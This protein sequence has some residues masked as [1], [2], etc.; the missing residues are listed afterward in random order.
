MNKYMIATRVTPIARMVE[1]KRTPLCSW[2]A[3]F[4][5]TGSIAHIS[6]ANKTMMTP[7]SF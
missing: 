1:V 5:T 3:N 2:N 7:I 6:A 4:A